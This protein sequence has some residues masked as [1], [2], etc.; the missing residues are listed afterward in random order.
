MP[1]KASRSS[2]AA[3]K[4]PPKTRSGG[5][6]HARSSLDTTT[7]PPTKKDALENEGS[8]A[9]A[10][11]ESIEVGSTGAKGK[12]AKANK[13]DNEIFLNSLLNTKINLLIDNLL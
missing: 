13:K 1:S 5:R 8:D 12:K 3:P 6:K 9:E 11:D 7:A 4:S 2:A 10:E